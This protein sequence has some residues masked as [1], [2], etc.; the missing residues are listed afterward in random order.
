[1]FT[2]TPIPISVPVVPGAPIPAQAL[3]GLRGEDVI[4]PPAQLVREGSFL[5]GRSGVV[6]TAPTGEQLVVFAPS[7]TGKDLPPMVL[8]PSPT[9][10]T[11]D[12][13]IRTTPGTL[14]VSLSGQVLVYHSRNY[15]LPTLVALPARAKPGQAQPDQP[16]QQGD[17]PDEPS[18][19]EASEPSPADDQRV[20]NLIA[21]LKRESE[22]P[23]VPTQP[24]H[25][26]APD[27]ASQR[28]VEH[29]TAPAT[30]RVI[31]E[32]ALMR[33]RGRLVRSPNGPWVFTI[34]S[35]PDS[36]APEP[37]IVLPGLA[38]QRI[39]P[40]ASRLGEPMVIEMS[41]R[42]LGYQGKAYLRPTMILVHRSFD[43]RTNQ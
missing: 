24:L 4:V 25:T 30:D 19:D 32:R 41:G 35:D 33:Q 34:D 26:P 36:P 13:A 43:L 15:L 6:L 12:D 40:I 1:V 16:P 22:R 21:D 31:P 39:E 7:A 11:I 17:Q 18:S 14:R 20:L 3:P 2:P 38:L 8:L 37:M 5:V 28:V 42:V 23:A 27:P 9:L 10:E 29:A